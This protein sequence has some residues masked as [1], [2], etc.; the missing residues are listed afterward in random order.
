MKMG[1]GNLGNGCFIGV[2]C[3]YCFKEGIINNGQEGQVPFLF[4]SILPSSL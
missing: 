2:W 4:I 1:K 3:F